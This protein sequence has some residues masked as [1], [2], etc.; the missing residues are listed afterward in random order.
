MHFCVYAEL[1]KSHDFSEYFNPFSM[2]FGYRKK[3]FSNY[4]V[5]DCYTH[6]Y[7][8]T[9]IFHFKKNLLLS[10]IIQAHPKKEHHHQHQRDDTYHLKD[11]HH[12][13]K[14]HEVEKDL[15]MNMS[16]EVEDVVIGID[17]HLIVV[18]L[19]RDMKE[20]EDQSKN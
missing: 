12:I 2:R 3:T 17:R 14:E 18:A 6:N 11:H 7:N 4:N 16:L 5:I 9:L 15:L 20:D 13:A 10:T 1:L 8:I 19:G